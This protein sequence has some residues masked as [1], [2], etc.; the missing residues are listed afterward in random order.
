MKKISVLLVDDS[1]FM[2]MVLSDIVNSFSEIEVKDTAINGKEAFEK[3]K[4]LRPDV[5]LLDITMEQFDGIYAIKHIMKECPTPIVVLSSIRTSNPAVVIEALNEGAVDF[6]DKPNAKIRD[7]DRHIYQKIKQAAAIDSN[8]LKNRKRSE[9]NNTHTFESQLNYQI[10][11]IGASTGGTG[12]IEQ[13]L[14]NIPHNMPIPIVIGQHMPPEFIYSFAERLDKIIPIKVKVAEQNE[15][16]KEGIIYIVPGN[17]NTRLVQ[18]KNEKPKFEFTSTQY[19]EYNHPS[20]DCLF[21]SVAKVYNAKSIAIILTGMG[22]DGKNGMSAIYNNGGYTI[23]QDEKTSVVYGMP[24]AVK[25]A[26]VV[27]RVISLQDIPGFIIS[28]IS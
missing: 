4:L 19:E 25:E 1:G 24:K 22:R 27:K 28:A 11:A 26:G 17:T 23:A 12:A 8:T 20:I 5:V 3:T 14:L 13:I 16:L 15:T 10:I 7:I 21:E 18:N 6:I 9:N 2:R